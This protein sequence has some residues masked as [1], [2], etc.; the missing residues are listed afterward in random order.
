MI[1]SG[2]ASGKDDLFY[3]SCHLVSGTALE[4]WES[5]EDGGQGE[6]VF[7]FVSN[8]TTLSSVRKRLLLYQVGAA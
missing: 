7:F 6:N 3:P 8:P 1:V 4:W 2:A 5:V